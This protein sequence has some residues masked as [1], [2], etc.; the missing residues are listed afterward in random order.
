MTEVI[1]AS[2]TTAIRYERDRPGELVPMDAREARTSPA[3]TG[4]A[5]PNG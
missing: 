1:K 5:V 2:K 3:R 4:S